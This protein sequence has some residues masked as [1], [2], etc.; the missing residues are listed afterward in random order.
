MSII[1]RG[2]G[3]C[4]HWLRMARSVRLVEEVDELLK[5]YLVLRLGARDLYHG[6][7]RKQ[8]GETLHG[9]ARLLTA[10]LLVCYVL[11]E[12]LENTF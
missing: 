1:G 10:D 4:R 6:C 8:A 7:T 5:I 3:V 11:V 9:K 2:W 12:E